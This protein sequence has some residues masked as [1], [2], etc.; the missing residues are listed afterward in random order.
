[1]ES[2]LLEA[3]SDLRQSNQSD[4]TN[5]FGD[6]NFQSLA[7]SSRSQLIE[8]FALY[9]GSARRGDIVT[10]TST[11]RTH[12]VEERNEEFF[13]LFPHRYDFIW[14]KYPNSGE[15][16]EWQTERRYPLSDRIIAQGS[17]LYG[18]RFGSRTSY[19]LLDIDAGSLYHPKNDPFAIARIIAALEP[20][21]IVSYLACTSS[22]SS[23]IHLYLPFEEAQS[24]WQLSIA[25]STLLENAGFILKP[26]QLEVFPNPKPYRGDR[27]FSLFNAHRLPLQI[28]SYLLNDDFQPIWSDRHTFLQYWNCVRSRNAVNAKTI[29]RIIKQ[30][31]R[32]P[33]R[34]SGKADKY[35]NDLN[36]EIEI[37]WTGAG[38]TNR[39]LGRI[40][41]RSYVFHHVLTSG[42]PLSGQKLVS[43]IVRVARS[44]PG[45]SDW[46]QHQHEIEHRAE[47]WAQCIESSHY[48]HYGDALGKYKA[49]IEKKKSPIENLPNWN[50]QQS[51]SAR[52]K[53]RSA[54]ADLLEKGVLPNSTTQRFKSLL[55]YR[56]G[57]GS[58]YRH[59]DLWHPS[60]LRIEDCE[61]NSVNEKVT[62]LIESEVSPSLLSG[63]GGNDFSH[64]GSSG[65]EVFVQPLNDEH[66]S[67]ELNDSS[68]DADVASQPLSISAEA[69]QAVS[70]EALRMAQE[71]GQPRSL[72]QLVRMQQFLESGDPIL[73]AEATAWFRI[74]FSLADVS[75]LR[76]LDR[77]DI[78]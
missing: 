46:C 44:L 2:F 53:I 50:E 30:F 1:M 38:Q 32:H 8:F 37:G 54:I 14:A 23:G 39:L 12:Y 10:S 61:I 31:K 33:F 17:T 68:C 42:S 55:E 45:Y 43:E 60:Y 28:G 11:E 9:L 74:K 77:D 56:I 75:E 70:Q 24:S 47:E 27:T 40:T 78:A 15:P 76:R 22:Y 41:M 35:L 73:V 69:Y 21:G 26:G 67:V 71:P 58:L 65:S 13:A 19:S 63:N 4:K 34:I 16:V 20:L 5:P 29:K 72:R 49:Q 48:F 3:L 6:A 57:G 25:I 59:K 51:K 18:V 36:A 64:D 7:E 52:E 62:S 66:Q